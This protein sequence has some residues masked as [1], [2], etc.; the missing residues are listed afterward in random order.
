MVPVRPAQW[1]GGMEQL[2]G[3]V[4]NLAASPWA[5]LLVAAVSCID[6]FFPPIPSESVVVAL[7][8][9]GAA[10]GHP[11]L[12]LLFI[13]AATGA[14]AGD[15]ITF[16][17]GRRLGTR[18]F[19]WMRRPRVA[20]TF[21]VAARTLRHRPALLILTARYI[22]VGRVA[23]NL[24]AGATG[25]RPSRFVPLSVL[26]GVSWAGYSILIG[27]VAGHWLQLHPLLGA[28]VAVLVAMVIGFL[29][30]LLVRRLIDRRA[31][32]RPT[33][34]GPDGVRDRCQLDDE[35]AAPRG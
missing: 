25:F 30:D 16:R 3:L 15:N 27:A 2:T 13:A 4:L 14:I 6:S 18:R 7:A 20:A 5:L 32:S 17:L 21:E 34:P 35:Q 33:D 22:P 11:H 19:G 31:P 23:V 29:V 26:A 10:T 28:L 8:A 12:A 24:T 1:D 9:T